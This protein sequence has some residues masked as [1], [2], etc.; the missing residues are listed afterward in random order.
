MFGFYLGKSIMVEVASGGSTGS[1]RNNILENSCPGAIPAETLPMLFRIP[2]NLAFDPNDLIDVCF[3]RTDS[4]LGFGDVV[5]PGLLIAY[6]SA[7]DRIKNIPFV[8][9][10]VSMVFYSI[11]LILTFLGNSIGFIDFNL[12]EFF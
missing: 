9:F 7:F 6:C 2:R 4:M 5:I 12:I 3:P 1:P 10:A 8:Y 11:G